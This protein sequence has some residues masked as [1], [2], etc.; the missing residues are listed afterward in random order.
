MLELQKFDNSIEDD[1][2][3]CLT[4]EGSVNSRDHL[5]GTAPTQVRKAVAV[6][7]IDLQNR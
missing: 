1:V 3:Q 7:K 2:F 5:G 6:G 4:L